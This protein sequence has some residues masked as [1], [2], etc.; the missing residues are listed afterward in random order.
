MQADGLAESAA[1]WEPVLPWLIIL[2]PLLGFFVN[3]ALALFAARKSADAVRAGGE[4]DFFENGHVVPF[5]LTGILLLVAIVGALV[6]A[7]KAS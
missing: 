6:L 2:L 5:E 7:K 3:G 1:T 4:L